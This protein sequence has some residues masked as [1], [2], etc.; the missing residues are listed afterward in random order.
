MSEMYEL[1]FSNFPKQISNSVF[2]SLSKTISSSKKHSVTINN[3]SQL[4]LIN[5]EN[6]EIYENL[7]RKADSLL[8]KELD[9]LYEEG[10]LT[11]SEYREYKEK[12][13]IKRTTE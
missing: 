3:F 7:K 2:E 10:V 6:R 8:A 13:I 1:D 12:T 5:G 4:I 11:E 9:K